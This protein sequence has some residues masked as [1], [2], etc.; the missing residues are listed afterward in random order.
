[1]EK[2]KV[3]SQSHLLSPLKVPVCVRLG[4]AGIKDQRH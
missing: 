1:M 2:Q 4:A 3:V